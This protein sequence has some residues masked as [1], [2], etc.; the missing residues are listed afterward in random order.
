MKV[1]LIDEVRGLGGRGDVVQVREGYARNYLLPKKLAREATTGNLKAAEA[2]RK[3]WASL[4]EQEKAAASKV[5]ERLRGVTV[6]IQKRTGETGTLFG[7]VTANEI[8]DAL[9]ARGFEIDKRRIELGHPIKTLGSQ[10]VEIRLHRE[11]DAMIS[12]EVVPSAG[13]ESVSVRL[14]GE[15]PAP[16]PAEESA[17]EPARASEPVTAEQPAAE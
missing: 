9:T 10:Q 8:A 4:T 16:A 11:V 13:D 17:P 2:E 1:I 7:S 6:V 12:V 15:E 3:K 5:A 14:P